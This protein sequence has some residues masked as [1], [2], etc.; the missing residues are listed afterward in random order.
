VSELVLGIFRPTVCKSEDKAALQRAVKE[1]QPLQYR[2]LLEILADVTKSFVDW[3]GWIKA[4]SVRVS[5]G[6]VDPLLGSRLCL[7]TVLLQTW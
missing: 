5:N 4:A 3:T 6:A 7:V 1:K 2:F